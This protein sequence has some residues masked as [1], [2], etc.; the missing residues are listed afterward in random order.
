VGGVLA[1][2][3]QDADTLVFFLS[4]NGYLWGEHGV[5]KKMLPYTP[6]IT[7]PLMVRWPGRV[8][9]GARDDRLAATIDVAPTILDAAGI[10]PNPE[11]AIDGR[12]LLDEW[13]RERLLIEFWAA[14]GR[15]TWAGLRSRSFLFAEYYKRDDE[16]VTFQEYYDLA[17]DPWEL[18][19]LLV[20]PV[21]KEVAVDVLHD[22]LAKA[23][24]C[25]GETC[26]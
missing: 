15:P 24:T 10:E 14:Y 21:P 1:A 2:T 25:A 8:D 4:D 12:S 26:P 11:V 3:D 7:I 22:Q 13:D 16:T 19:N 20:D 5:G 6:S 17:N 23:R 9:A 18:D